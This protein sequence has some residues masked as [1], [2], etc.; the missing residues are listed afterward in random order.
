MTAQE[1][2]GECIDDA[3]DGSIMVDFNM[4]LAFLFEHKDTSQQALPG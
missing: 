2:P 4:L 1:A 3:T